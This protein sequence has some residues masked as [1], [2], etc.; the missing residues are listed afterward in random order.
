LNGDLDEIIDSL[1]AQDQAMRL[2]A[3]DGSHTA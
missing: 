2:A 1:T 3:A